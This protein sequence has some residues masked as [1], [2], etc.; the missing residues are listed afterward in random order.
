[1][2]WSEYALDHFKRY[3]STYTVLGA[4][5]GAGV[6]A[7]AIAA[8]TESTSAGYTS[9]LHEFNKR[10]PTV[11]V[12]VGFG[13]QLVPVSQREGYTTGMT[14]SSDRKKEVKRMKVKRHGNDKKQKSSK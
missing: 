14:S 10:A 7:G 8:G 13:Y 12:P 1:M 11:R 9:G 3:R 6:V 4:A 5:I 2:T